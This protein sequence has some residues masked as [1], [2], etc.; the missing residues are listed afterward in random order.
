MTNL[1][2]LAVRFC[3]CTIVSSAFSG[4]CHTKGRLL[5]GDASCRIYDTLRISSANA[6]AGF[7]PPRTGN[8]LDTDNSRQP[9]MPA[10][11]S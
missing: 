9:A 2:T 11:N 1:Y 4:Y 5:P 7:Q 10:M 6:T 3:V 8:T